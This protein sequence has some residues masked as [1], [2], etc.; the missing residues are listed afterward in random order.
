MNLASQLPSQVGINKRTGFITVGILGGGSNHRSTDVIAAV[1][2]GVTDS[3]RSPWLS[4]QKSSVPK[5]SFCLS[6]SLSASSNAGTA[7]KSRKALQSQLG[8]GKRQHSQHDS[9][10]SSNADEESKDEA[11]VSDQRLSSDMQAYQKR[12]AGGD[13]VFEADEDEDQKDL[14]PKMHVDN[15]RL[16]E[17]D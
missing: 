3:L 10:K 9:E 11:H 1:G 6:M 4:Q 15:D 13:A 17:N 5:S 16:I 12:Y 8:E 7:L 2:G 14:S